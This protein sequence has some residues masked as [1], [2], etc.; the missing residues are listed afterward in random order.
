MSTVRP[1][2]LILENDVDLAALLVRTL[3]EQGFEAQSVGLVRDFERRLSQVRPA[4]CIVDMSLPD[5]AGFEV[6]ARRLKSDAIP[7]IAISGVWTDVSYRVMGLEMGADD[8]LLKP[9]DPR[10]LVARMRAVLR[11]AEGAASTEDN[12]VRF[13]GWM[14]DLHSHRLVAPDGEEID[15]SAS[16]V[17]LLRVLALRPQRVQTRETLM[18]WDEAPGN[19]AFDRSIDV[20]ISRL[21]AKLRE[22][23]RNPQIIKTVYGAGYMFTPAVEWSRGG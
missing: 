22:D 1:L 14:A 16:E 11:R 18:E 21:R 7:A 3:D 13:A 2:V 17:R 10:E 15:L 5:G 19:I 23:P 8:Y 6:M 4:I 9:I 12:I 20:R